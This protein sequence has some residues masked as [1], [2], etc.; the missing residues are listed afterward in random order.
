MAANS[1][2]GTLSGSHSNVIPMTAPP[3]AAPSTT[4]F[5]QPVRA[6]AMIGVYAPAMAR[7]IAE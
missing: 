5:C 4:T 1:G 3:H 2:R 7:K 6:T